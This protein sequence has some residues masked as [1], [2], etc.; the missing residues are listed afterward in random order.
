MEIGIAMPSKHGNILSFVV[1]VILE[2]DFVVF[3]SNFTERDRSN[4]YAIMLLLSLCSIFL[5][6]ICAFVRIIYRSRSLSSFNV[7]HFDRSHR[8]IISVLTIL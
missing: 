3:T 5:V 8:N 1:P 2:T 6:L 4:V 7:R